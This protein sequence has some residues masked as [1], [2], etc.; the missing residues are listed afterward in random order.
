MMWIGRHD[1]ITCMISTSYSSKITADK[2]AYT[3]NTLPSAPLPYYQPT[4]PH[5]T[6]YNVSHIVVAAHRKE[7]HK[8]TPQQLEIIL[9][10]QKYP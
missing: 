9:T 2:P 1:H 6:T 4:H 3:A 8:N 7:G 10:N 5:R